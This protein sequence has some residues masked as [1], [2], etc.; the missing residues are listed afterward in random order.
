MDG[1]KEYQKFG[2]ALK[3]QEEGTTVDDYINLSYSIYE[4]NG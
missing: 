3:N 4:E 1:G 2:W